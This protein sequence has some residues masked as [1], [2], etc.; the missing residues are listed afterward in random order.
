MPSLE[1]ISGGPGLTKDESLTDRRPLRRGEH[2][3]EQLLEAAMA[4]FG[5]RGYDG[6]SVVDIAERAQIAKSVI[7]D[8]FASKAELHRAL[9]EAEGHALLAHVADSVPPPPTASAEERLR[10]G[11]DAFLSYVEA[12]PSSWRLLV[13]DAPA[14]PELSEVHARVQAE[15]TNAILAL[16]EPHAPADPDKRR[17]KEMLAELLK[18]AISGLASWWYEH[19]EV[20]RRELVDTVMEFAWRGLERQAP[21]NS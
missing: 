20:P 15:A 18:T 8:H 10:A 12:R 1:P 9:V 4:V 6:T 16:I 3:R 2:R 11:V 7:Y 14:H 17:H 19:R 21:G 5:E 13:R